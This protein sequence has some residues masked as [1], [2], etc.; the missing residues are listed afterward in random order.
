MYADVNVF[1]ELGIKSISERD[2]KTA[3]P[4]NAS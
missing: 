2:D 1:E 3:M 4:S